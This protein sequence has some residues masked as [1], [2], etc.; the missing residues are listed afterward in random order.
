MVSSVS[1]GTLAQS[2]YCETGDSVSIRYVES[3]RA[4]PDVG[5]SDRPVT[6]PFSRDMETVMVMFQSDTPMASMA[7]VLSVV[8]DVSWELDEVDAM[9]TSLAIFLI[10]E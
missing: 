7:T 5:A 2:L 1:R 9:S 4:G 6:P 8:D 10:Q 3:P